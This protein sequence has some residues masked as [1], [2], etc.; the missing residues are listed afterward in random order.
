MN[1]KDHVVFGAFLHDI[2]KLYERAGIL[3]QYAKD[4]F[5]QQE[6]CPNSKGYY[7]H[8]HV[9]YTLAF[10]EE[11][12]KHIPILKTA[13]QSDENWINI[14]SRH[15][16]ASTPLEHIVSKADRLASGEREGESIYKKSIHKKGLLE[17]LLEKV[18]LQGTNE[19]TKHRLDLKALDSFENLFPQKSEEL[20][21]DSETLLSPNELTDKYK[22]LADN[23]LSSLQQFPEYK[24]P[25]FT[26][27]RSVICSLLSQF[28][29]FLVNIPSATNVKSPDI[30]LFDHLKITSAIAEALYMHHEK[31]NSLDEINEI[32]KEE[33]WILVCGDFSGIQKFIYSLVS[34]GAAK[35]LAGRSFY[36]QLFCDAVSEWLLRSMNIYP[37]SCIYSSGGKFYLLLAKHLADEVRCKISFINEFLFKK[38]KGQIHL[39]LGIVSLCEEDFNSNSISKKFECVNKELSLVKNRKFFDSIKENPELFFKAQ[40]VQKDICS[41]CGSDFNNKF[42]QDEDDKKCADCKSFEKIGMAIRNISETKTDKPKKSSDNKVSTNEV[43]GNLLWVWSAEEAYKIE[44]KL[45]N[46]KSGFEL[47]S[48]NDDLSA[49][50][51]AFME[52]KQAKNSKKINIKYESHKEKP[53]QLPFLKIYVLKNSDNKKSANELEKSSDNELSLD[54]IKELGLPQSHLETV[55]SILDLKKLKSLSIGHRFIGFCS[56]DLNLDEIVKKSK[57]IERIGILRMDVDNLGQVFIRGLSYKETD[58]SGENQNKTGEK[59]DDQKNLGSLSRQASLS[60]QINVFFTGYLMKGIMPS[61]EDCKVIYSGGDDLFI[62]GPW[63]KL[64]ELAFKIKE[65]FSRYCCHN[66]DLTLSAGIALIT[67]K[68]P[69]LNGADLAGKAEKKAKQFDRNDYGKNSKPVNTKSLQQKN[70]LCFLDTVIGWEEY[71]EVKKFKKLIKNLSDPTA[72]RSILSVLFYIDEEIKRIKEAKNHNAVN[73]N[74]QMDN[75]IQYQAWRYRFVYYLA[76]MSERYEKK[77]KVKDLIDKIRKCI[78]ENQDPEIGKFRHP[79]NWLYMP[80]RWLDYLERE[81]DQNSKNLSKPA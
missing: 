16:K 81:K 37:T 77:D 33:K 76:R 56:G 32:K 44:R 34:K 50:A 23:L 49:P 26:S 15:H 10:C 13:Y 38:Y 3:S 28:E 17:S 61:F 74:N 25:D 30:S 40:P 2:G 68:Y 79:L 62:I 46:K 14:A 59:E 21:L 7:S 80:T 63:H 69:I 19:K 73:I 57:G 20:K 67:K 60:R 24:K 54:K 51:Q 9:L 11:L 27:L 42:D 41:V 45:S 35:G 78:L 65:D 8:R 6:Y 47:F 31:N 43:N 72:S 29:R 71:K 4:E 70:A 66:P 5:K 18:S 52:E 55:N 12:Q 58:K 64:P 48:L 1:D 39:N 53:H 75:I 22:F 36:I